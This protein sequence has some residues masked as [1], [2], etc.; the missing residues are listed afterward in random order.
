MA[1]GFQAQEIGLGIFMTVVQRAEINH[2]REGKF[3][4]NSW[5][6]KSLHGNSKM[7]QIADDEDPLLR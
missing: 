5:D 2:R 1:S 7:P 3:Y 4:K 6:A